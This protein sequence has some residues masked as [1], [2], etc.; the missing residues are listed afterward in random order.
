MDGPTEGFSHDATDH[1]RFHNLV[2]IRYVGIERNMIENLL[3]HQT[4]LLRFPSN[5]AGKSAGERS[6]QGDV[7]AV[8]NHDAD[9]MSDV[10]SSFSS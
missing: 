3:T 4:G 9:D 8:E 5:S 2:G 6:D 10:K 7:F 1:L